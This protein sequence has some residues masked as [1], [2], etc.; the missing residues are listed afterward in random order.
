MIMIARNRPENITTEI[1]YL[2]PRGPRVGR[3]VGPGS[4]RWRVSRSLGANSSA[5]RS[6][7]ASRPSGGHLA[8]HVA[9]R[10]RAVTQ[11]VASTLDRV[12]REASRAR[13][14]RKTAT[15]DHL[16]FRA[17]PQPR[18]ALIH[19]ALERG[20]LRADEPFGRQAICRSRSL[21]PADPKSC[22]RDQLSNSRAL[23]SRCT[24]P[25]ESAST[26][27]A[28]DARSTRTTLLTCELKSLV[29]Y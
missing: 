23:T 11:F 26:G 9:A 25:S 18:H 10:L 15:P 24:G 12:E 4:I 21:D 22:A 29:V 6:R 7:R 8:R 28:P 5:R 3:G 19:R 1:G 27:F 16:C 13:D 14:D 17:R 2:S 20:E